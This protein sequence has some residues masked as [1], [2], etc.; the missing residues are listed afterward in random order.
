MAVGPSDYYGAY[1]NVGFQR[2]CNTMQHCLTRV[3]HYNTYS[4]YYVR[5]SAFAVDGCTHRPPRLI[6]HFLPISIIIVHVITVPVV[7]LHIIAFCMI[8]WGTNIGR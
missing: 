4:Y 1:Q 8:W 6:L 5:Y 3:L 2:Q 7:Q